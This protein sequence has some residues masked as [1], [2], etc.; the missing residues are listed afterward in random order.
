MFDHQFWAP[1]LR[2][3]P[4]EARVL[5]EVIQDRV[6]P[7]FQG[8]EDEAEQVADS[9]YEEL[10]QLPADEYSYIDMSDL[11]EIA[12]DKGLERYE[13]LAGA[14]QALLNIAPV[15]LYHLFEQQLLF[16]YRR[17][18]L[19]PSEEYDRSR[20]R[21]LS[22]VEARLRRDGIDLHSFG[23]WPRIHELRHIANTI[24]HAEGDAADS[25]RTLRP[26]LFVVPILRNDPRWAV[27]GGSRVDLPLAG[28]DIYITGED[29]CIYLRAVEEFWNEFAD[30]I[31]HG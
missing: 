17:Q 12:H 5:I 13:E 30:A 10:G 7:A 6:L 4:R 24:K 29:L 31:E 23:S 8:I 16:F 19:H 2:R 11:A 22:V 28:D 14:K 15:A 1:Q 3:F 26:D 21:H 27:R 25:L 20:F 9:V 18:V